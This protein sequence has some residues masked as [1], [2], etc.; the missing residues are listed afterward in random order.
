M[1]SGHK[2]SMTHRVL[3]S[4]RS[5]MGVIYM[6]SWKQCALPVITTKCMSCHKAIVVITGRAHCFHDNIYNDIIILFSYED[7]DKLKITLSGLCLSLK[8]LFEE[9]FKRYFKSE[10]SKNLLK[11]SSNNIFS[12]DEDVIKFSNLYQCIFNWNI[13]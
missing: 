6:L 2:W 5:K 7:E 10:R 11:I 13:A 8:I 3:K 1:I 9:I 12:E 4:H